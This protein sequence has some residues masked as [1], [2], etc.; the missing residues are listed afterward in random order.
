MKKYRLPVLC[1][2]AALVLPMTV[3][4]GSAD[5]EKKQ[6]QIINEK[7]KVYQQIQRN[8]NQLMSIESDVAEVNSEIV[9]LDKKINSLNSSIAGLESDIVRL[10]E[11]IIKTKQELDEAN[12]NLEEKKELFESRLRAMYMNGKASYLEVI[13]NSKNMEELIRNNEVIVSISNGDKELVEYIAEQ[14]KT[15]EEK[16]YKLESDKNTL[17]IAKSSL[18]IERAEQQKISVEKRDYMQALVSDAE[19]Y[20]VEYERAEAQWKNLDK[21]I[22][23]LQSQIKELKEQERIAREQAAK[24]GKAS[25]RTQGAMLWPVPGNTSISSGYGNRLHPIL[26]TY[27]FH[28]GI[29][30]PAAGGTPVVAVKS[31]IVIM[32][33]S[34][35]GYGNVV[36]IDH[37]DIVTV[38]AHNSSLKA[39]VGQRVNGGDVIATVGSTGLSTGPHLHFEVRVNGQAVNPLGYV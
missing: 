26:K 13:L 6:Q 39:S 22:L 2:T 15:I 21:E 10:N 30:I 23:R 17:A 27:R 36:M 38:Y 8:K 29:D 24:S 7:N 19:A 31:G 37:G 18:E 28:S 1:L 11:E 3:Y 4:G 9:I 34:M 20:K 12:A 25:A 33:K 5:L 32:S 35:G 16:S 14:I